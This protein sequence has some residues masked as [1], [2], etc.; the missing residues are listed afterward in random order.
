MLVELKAERGEP[1]WIS[2]EGVLVVSSG[3]RGKED[4]Q[5][6]LILDTAEEAVLIRG[7][8]AEQVAD[9]LNSASDASA[10]SFVELTDIDGSREWINA[11][12][13]RQLRAHGTGTELVMPRLQLVG[14]VLR[15]MSIE[16]LVVRVRE[17]PEAVRDR[18]NGVAR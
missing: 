10:P 3:A 13:I 17:S 11:R 1:I 18:L 12:Q 14:R 4:V 2:P 9:R 5:C 16:P 7:C 15:P 8:S 6:G